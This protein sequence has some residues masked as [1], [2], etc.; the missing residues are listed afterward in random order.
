MTKEK[1]IQYRKAYTELNEILNVLSP[2]QKNKIPQ[3]VINNVKNNMDKHY[4]FHFDLS[5]GI[6]EQHLMV[7]T[8]ALLIKIYETYLASEEEKELWNQYDRFC[9]HKIEEVKKSKYDINI[10]ENN[11]RNE[12]IKK[13]SNDKRIIQDNKEKFPIKYKKENIVYKLLLF[14]KRIFNNKNC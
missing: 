14:L 10:F 11:K 3:I 12:N 4:I 7:E 13:I 8:E 5:K 2:E 6:F 1:M 9:S